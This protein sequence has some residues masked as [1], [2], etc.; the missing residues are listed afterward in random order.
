[1]L[2]LIHL[3]TAIL[4]Q[5]VV[6]KID[7]KNQLAANKDYNPAQCKWVI[8]EHGNQLK[9]LV[10]KQVKRWWTAG[11][12]GKINLVVRYGNKPV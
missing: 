3:L 1:L 11:V 4:L 12:D 7:E 6:A 2:L 5:F 8:D 9:V 10:T